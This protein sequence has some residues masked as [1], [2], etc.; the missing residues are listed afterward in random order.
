[1]E[2]G[3]THD[4]RASIFKDFRETNVIKYLAHKPYMGL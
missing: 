1:M 4:S 2:S 3:Q